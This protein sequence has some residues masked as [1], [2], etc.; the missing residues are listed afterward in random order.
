MLS[1]ERKESAKRCFI[2]FRFL[3]YSEKCS[4]I[5]GEGLEA[6]RNQAASRSQI[7]IPFELKEHNCT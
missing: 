7:N 5:D 3:K 4:G 6:F 1:S 2:C